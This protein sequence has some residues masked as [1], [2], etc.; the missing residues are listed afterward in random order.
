MLHGAAIPKLFLE[1][2]LFNF[3]FY[4]KGKEK[5]MYTRLLF[6]QIAAG[7][8]KPYTSEYVMDEL[9]DA[10]KKQFE[11]MYTLIDTYGIFVL[12]ES[13]EI[14][15]LSAIYVA[16]EIIPVGSEPDSDHIAAA[17]VNGLDFVV[18]YNMGHIVKQK[19]MIATG[20][21]NKREGYAQIGIANPKEVMEYDKRRTA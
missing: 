19:T 12:P 5:M 14:D 13:G 8:Y 9:R 6:D 20:F 10:P 7:I 21:A 2:T 4:G 15:R 1:T 18:S 17:T 16:N 11:Q 3:Y